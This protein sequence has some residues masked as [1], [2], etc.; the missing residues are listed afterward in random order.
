MD[1]N[2]HKKN[3]FQNFTVGT[4]GIMYTASNKRKEKEIYNS[5]AIHID[6]SNERGDPNEKRLFNI[7]VN[8]YK[9]VF[10]KV[11]NQRIIYGSDILIKV[12]D[13][14]KLKSRTRKP[15]T[16]NKISL[17]T[18][19]YTN[20]HAKDN[21]NSITRIH[22]YNY[23]NTTN[24]HSPI[25]R[26]TFDGSTMFH[27]AVYSPQHMSYERIPRSPK[28]LNKTLSS[29]VNKINKENECIKIIPKLKELNE[30]KYKYIKR[31]WDNKHKDKKDKFNDVIKYTK[32]L[33]SVKSRNN[34]N[35]FNKS[36]YKYPA[37]NR[38]IYGKKYSCGLIE[39]ANK[40]LK[41]IA[42]QRQRIFKLKEL[43]LMLSTNTNEDK[44]SDNDT[45][46]KLS[47]VESNNN[48]NKSI[49]NSDI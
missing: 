8:N 12:M 26:K 41:E 31:E 10:S 24:Y 11:G 22:S 14:M 42:N 3:V 33:Y 40:K 7:N 47:F 43:E 49:H 37:I 34:K 23:I 6:S 38:F 2:Y 16:C 30:M 13:E 9:N 15:I 46:N 4:H 25:M 45:Q 1:N 17:Y 44:G 35:V 36:M 19:P 29:I 28:E 32:Q 5:T 21:K 20:V 18:K 39:N 27:S 48:N